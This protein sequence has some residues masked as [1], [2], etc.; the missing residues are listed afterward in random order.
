MKIFIASDHTGIELRETMIKILKEEYSWEVIKSNVENNPTDDFSDFAFDILLKANPQEDYCIL[1]CGNGIGMSIA[2][3]K[4]KGIY[5][6]RVVNEEEV[7]VAKGHNNINAIAFAAKTPIS[8]AIK[9]V[10]AL[11]NTPKTQE[12]KRIR[13]NNKIAIYEEA[14]K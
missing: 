13:R 1:I 8:E 7:I 12:E 9:Y 2:A 11:V 10:I 3:N 5:C 14:K 4:V 6:A